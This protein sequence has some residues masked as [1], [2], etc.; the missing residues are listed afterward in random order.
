MQIS[1]YDKS[2]KGYIFWSASM[3]GF[4]IYILTAALPVISFVLS[5]IVIAVKR[6][7]LFIL[8]II[9]VAMVHPLVSLVIGF[10]IATFSSCLCLRPFDD[11]L[12]YFLKKCF[13]I[14][15]RTFTYSMNMH[16]T[17][18]GAVMYYIFQAWADLGQASIIYYSRKSFDQC[19][20]SYLEMLNMEMN[21]HLKCT[22]REHENFQNYF[23]DIPIDLVLIVFMIT[24]L[25]CHLL[26]AW[27]LPIPPPMRLYDFIIGTSQNMDDQQQ[28]QEFEIGLTWHKIKGKVIK[29]IVKPSIIILALV[30]IA[31]LAVIPHN[32]HLFL[33]NSVEGKKC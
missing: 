10:F 20:C 3:T 29:Y 17:V 1:I 12:N 2:F 23:L 26:Q 32:F 21:L 9:M 28:T 22:D 30:Y 19:R 5:L 18:I 27:I 13:Q 15:G 6:Q 33:E 24:S 4:T 25:A 14:I 31:V 7:C 11:S 16:F 8:P